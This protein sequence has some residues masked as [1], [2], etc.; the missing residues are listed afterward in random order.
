M[1]S[2]SELQRGSNPSNGGPRKEEEKPKVLVIMGPTGSG[3]SRL[4]IDLAAHFPIEIINADSMQ[5][6]EG[7]DVLTNKVPLH[8]Q[9][10]VPHHLL[11]T[12]SPNVEFTA[13]SFRDSAISIINGIFSRKC[14]PVIVGGTNY[15]IQALVSSFLIDDSLE[16]VDEICSTDPSEDEQTDCGPDFRRQSCNYRIHLNNH[17]DYGDNFGRDSCNYDILKDLDPV[18][19]NRIHP[20][21]HRKINQYL[22]LYSRTGIL[23]SE[24]YQGKAAENWGQVGDFRYNCC[25]ICV[26]AA[27]PEL[28]QYVEQRVDCMIDSGLLG[29]VYNIYNVNADY[30]RGLRQAIGVREFENF[31]RIYLSG[32]RTNDA[33]DSSKDSPS[34]LSTRVGDKMLKENIRAILNSS[35]DN[36]HK[37][38]LEDAI[39]NVKA[40]TRRLVRRQKRRLKRLQA[41]FGWTIHYVDSTDSI[42]GKLDECWAEQVVEP[43]AK[44]IRSFLN[45][46]A[47]SELNLEETNKT[48]T[49]S[50]HRDLWTQYVCKACGDRTLRGAHEWE[51]HVQGRGH[52]KRVS[53]L[54]KLR[55]VPA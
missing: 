31:L 40:N 47:R 10:G 7:L 28:D 26:D 38:L 12:V 21:N 36:Q 14:L 25:F 55:D 23:P 37:I 39:G 5:V 27:N 13:K 53:H 4:A 20:N 48:K 9:K 49:N 18:A 41:L 8:E 11:G 15:Y 44:I 32:V 6:Y 17:Q 35:N 54:R 22:D 30:T 50:I 52:R 2:S 51:Q 3:K 33:S 19:A 16:D 24:L 43:A 45:E 46:D 29:E 42:S 1:E 34:M